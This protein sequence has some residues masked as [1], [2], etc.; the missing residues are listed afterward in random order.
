MRRALI[1]AAVLAVVAVAAALWGNRG[2]RS[3]P[4]PDRELGL[5]KTALDDDRVP[6]SFVFPEAMPGENARLPKSYAG[7]PPLVP[8]T[9]DGLLPITR[10][11]NLCVTCHATGS[12]DP[13]DPPQ[14]PISHRT[15][16]R[17]APTVVR[18]SV[19]GARWVC[20]TC[21]VPQSN[22]PLLVG[23]TFEAAKGKS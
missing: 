8:H 16:L 18:D 20:T 7:A 23:S 15:D 12:T 6:A 22:A 9:L 19:A 17:A 3:V 21:H 13:A 5:R 10:G 14:V 11:D 2:V 4:V 1:V